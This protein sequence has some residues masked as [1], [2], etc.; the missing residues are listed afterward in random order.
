MPDEGP[1]LAKE[2]WIGR[3]GVMDPQ[4]LFTEHGVMKF[5]EEGRPRR[6]WKVAIEVGDEVELIRPAS[7]LQ[8]KAAGDG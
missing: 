6:V 2:M 8:V 7:Y 4:L 1:G 3:T 5:L